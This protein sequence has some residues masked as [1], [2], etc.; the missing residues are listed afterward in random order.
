[1][2]TSEDLLDLVPNRIVAGIVG[3]FRN[4]GGLGTGESYIPVVVFDP[5]L[6]R[7]PS[8]SYRLRHPVYLSRRCPLVALS[9]TEVH[10]SCQT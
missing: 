7:S 5:L 6:Y 2:C 10:V 8:E 9:V 4:G 1:M 3:V